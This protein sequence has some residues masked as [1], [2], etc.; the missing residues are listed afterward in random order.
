MRAEIARDR[1]CSA[2][3]LQ[4]MVLRT[5]VAQLARQRIRLGDHMPIGTQDLRK[6]RFA[7]A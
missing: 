4:L 7:K 5:A 1:D 6:P 3:A 2:S